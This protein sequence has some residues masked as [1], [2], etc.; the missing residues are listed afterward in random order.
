M[1]LY[2]AKMERLLT[3]GWVGPYGFYGSWEFT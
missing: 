1:Q 2:E 3:K